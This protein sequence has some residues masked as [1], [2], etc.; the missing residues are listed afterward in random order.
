VSKRIYWPFED[1]VAFEGIPEEKLVKFRQVRQQI[2]AKIRDWLNSEQIT[3]QEP[4]PPLL[5]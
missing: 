3:I 4:D 2:D 5:F 1:P